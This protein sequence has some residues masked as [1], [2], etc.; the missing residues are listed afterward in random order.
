VVIDVDNLATIVATKV[1]GAP[2]AGLGP[3]PLTAS[4]VSPA[5]PAVTPGPIA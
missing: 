5:T 3:T 1:Q 2:Q 4:E